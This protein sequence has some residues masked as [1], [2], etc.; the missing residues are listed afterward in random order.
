[1]CIRDSTEGDEYRDITV[2]RETV[3]K[4]AL[5]CLDDDITEGKFIRF[6][7]G[8]MPIAEAF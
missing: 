4:A 1:M 5:A 8:P 6:C 2:S 7:D 3:A